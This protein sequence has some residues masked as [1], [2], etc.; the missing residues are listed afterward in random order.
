MRQ[1]VFKVANKANLSILI[2]MTKFEKLQLLCRQYLKEI[3]N[4]AKKYGLGTFVS[5]LAIANKNGD[6]KADV[7]DVELLARIA[8]DERINRLDVPKLL[9]MSYRQCFD[10]GIFE[11]IERFEDRG[12]YSRISTELYKC[13]LEKEEINNG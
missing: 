1:N 13:E 8:K 12:T 3:K 4:V 10:Q 5:E 7:N 2:Y 9:G 11:K 6:C